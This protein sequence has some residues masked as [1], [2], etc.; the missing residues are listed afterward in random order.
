MIGFS[1]CFDA[2][3]N[4][5]KLSLGTHQDALIPGAVEIAASADE[6]AHPFPWT[7]TVTVALNEIRFVPLPHVRSTPAEQLH[8]SG[9][10]SISE[11]VFVPPC[12]PSEL[13]QQEQEQVASHVA[14][15]I[16][17][18]DQLPVGHEGLEEIKSALEAVGIQMIPLITS[19]HASLHEGKVEGPV[20][21]YAAPGWI[22]HSKVYRKALVR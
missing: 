8:Q 2:A 7:T 12:D 10:I 11:Y 22:S 6:L 15:L 13:G 3:G 1:Y 14:E 5:I 21:E 9:Q 4:L 20:T 17:L 18:Y 16:A 19:F